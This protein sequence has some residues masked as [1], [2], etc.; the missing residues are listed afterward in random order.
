MGVRRGTLRAGM[1][2]GTEAVE[3]ILREGC[4]REAMPVPGGTACPHSA[5]RSA[6]AGALPS[7]GG[8]GRRDDVGW[9]PCPTTRRPSR[10]RP[11]ASRRGLPRVLRDPPT[12]MR[13]MQ[14]LASTRC[15]RLAL[16]AFSYESAQYFLFA[17]CSSP[18]YIF[19]VRRLR[20]AFPTLGVMIAVPPM[21]SRHR[22]RGASS[23]ACRG[24][25]HEP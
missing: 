9:P 15:A 12:T 22:A 18:S 3:G 5:S 6:G 14:G 11:W 16:F 4:G 19:C 24:L 25:L 1:E 2:R 20:D 8:S 10:E 23:L 13:A 21:R 17:E 7:D